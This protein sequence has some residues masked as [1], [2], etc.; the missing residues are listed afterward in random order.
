MADIFQFQEKVLPLYTEFIPHLK[1][2]N[3]KMQAIEVLRF[4]I[5]SSTT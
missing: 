5:S 2:G 1:E 4:L 3:R